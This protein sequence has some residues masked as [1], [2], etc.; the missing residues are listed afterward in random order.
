MNY[1]TEL[2]EQPLHRALGLTDWEADRIRELLGRDE[3]R[4]FLDRR[5]GR[6]LV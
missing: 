4:Q 1:L 2:A 3:V 6:E 5:F